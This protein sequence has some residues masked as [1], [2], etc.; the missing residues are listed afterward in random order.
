MGDRLLNL[1][2]QGAGERQGRHHSPKKLHLTDVDGEVAGADRL[3]AFDDHGDHLGIGFGARQADQ[4]HAALKNLPIL[5]GLLFGVAQNPA[6]ITE[7][8][9]KGDVAH[10]GGDDAGHL[11]RDVRGDGEKFAA[12]AVVEAKG[13]L[14]QPFAKAPFQDVE[15]FE[16]RRHDRPESPPGEDAV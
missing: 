3:Q 2:G 6:G 16:R 4:F 1:Q 14:A 13:A 5:A 10:T 9:G 15:I 12:L 11:R 8:V 7:T